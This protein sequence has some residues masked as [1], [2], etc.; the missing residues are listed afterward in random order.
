MM[1]GKDPK[2]IMLACIFL[3][4]KVGNLHLEADFITAKVAGSD[5]LTVL[6]LEFH[7]LSQIQFELTFPAL[8][9]A[10]HGALLY[11]EEFLDMHR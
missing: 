11:Y 9:R 2:H 1:Q 8:D 6:Q 4:T 10:L 3:G 5:P 7:I